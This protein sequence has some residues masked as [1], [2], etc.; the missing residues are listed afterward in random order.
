[1]LCCLG[2]EGRT[3]DEAYSLNISTDPQESRKVLATW[4]NVSRAHMYFA[5]GVVN[6][7]GG[8]GI[9]MGRVKYFGELRGSVKKSYHVQGGPPKLSSHFMRG[10]GKNI[11]AIKEHFTHFQTHNC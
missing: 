11:F 5:Y 7:Y 2:D 6:N 10:R 4:Q 3:C 9:E 1:M 8:G